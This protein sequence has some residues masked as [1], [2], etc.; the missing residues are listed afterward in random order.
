MQPVAVGGGPLGVE[1][2]AGAR[3]HE[4]R[5]PSQV[6]GDVHVEPVVAHGQ[7]HA[8]DGAPRV[9]P[10]LLRAAVVGPTEL[11]DDRRRER[12]CGLRLGSRRRCVGAS[13]GSGN[14]TGP[15]RRGVRPRI[16]DGEPHL[17]RGV[18]GALLAQ[19]PVAPTVGVG[20]TVHVRHPGRDRHGDGAVGI[21]AAARHGLA[22]I[23]HHR[24]RPRVTPR[25]HGARGPGPVAGCPRRVRAP[26]L[27]ARGG[28]DVEPGDARLHVAQLAGAERQAQAVR[29]ERRG[30]G[31]GKEVEAVLEAA[32][33]RARD[34][35]PGQL[36]V[37]RAV[38]RA[39]VGARVDQPA[40]QREVERA[41]AEPRPGEAVDEVVGREHQPPPRDHAR[42][43]LRLGTD[44]LHPGGGRHVEAE[45]AAGGRRLRAL[46][47]E[48]GRVRERAP[49]PVERAVHVRAGARVD[50]VG[51]E[52]DVE[53]V[54]VA[55]AAARQAVVE[56]RVPLRVRPAQNSEP[57]LAQEHRPEPAVRVLGADLGGG[58]LGAREQERLPAEARARQVGRGLVA[59]R[60]AR[61]TPAAGVAGVAV[62]AVVE[63]A[64]PA[65]EEVGSAAGVGPVVRR[66][67]DAQLQPLRPAPLAERHPELRVAPRRQHVP[68]HG[69]EEGRREPPVEAGEERRVEGEARVL[70]HHDA[71][72][73]AA[74]GELVVVLALVPGAVREQPVAQQ[75]G[76][77]VAPV[78]GRLRA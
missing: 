44:G 62:R 50:E 4:G 13:S 28:V 39:V 68:R 6:H 12:P 56:R 40:A 41:V 52:L 74:V 37:R 27:G 32:R 17:A 75:G 70:R 46:A 59:L 2:V 10:R 38:E 58:E 15:L 57:L 19:R 48:R 49:V 71:V 78:H 55:V 54:G 21:H 31:V 61:G 5:G 14:V 47:D 33:A 26:E 24:D 11:R 66:P 36:R 8:R 77:A 73:Q 20:W 1:R 51:R 45:E 43:D 34:G 42:R 72:P 60:L 64:E 65:G 69:D 18:A 63:P 25:A 7:G 76:D 9:V 67:G 30:S 23:A 29:V 35:S 3:G 22:E 53:P 16:G